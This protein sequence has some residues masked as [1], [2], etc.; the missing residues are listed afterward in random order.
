MFFLPSL[1]PKQI[2]KN[3]LAINIFKIQIGLDASGFW[4]ILLSWSDFR[5]EKMDE[6]KMNSEE[7]TAAN[8]INDAIETMAKLSGGYP[9]IPIQKFVEQW[10]LDGEQ[11]PEYVVNVV[12]HIRNKRYQQTA[13]SHLKYIIKHGPVHSAQYQNGGA[14]SKT[15]PP[16]QNPSS[17]NS[18]NDKFLGEFSSPIGMV[19]SLA[20]LLAILAA[21]VWILG[22]F[23]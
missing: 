10:F 17:N 6:S 19:F 1:Y 21:V 2:N 22:S 14:L 12:S 8:S 15:E 5:T 16:K 4:Q 9:K 18:P 3:C 7:T 13:I 23:I 11:N 20:K